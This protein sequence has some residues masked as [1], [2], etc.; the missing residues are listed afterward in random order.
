LPGLNDWVSPMKENAL[1]GFGDHGEVLVLEASLMNLVGGGDTCVEIS[2][3]HQRAESNVHCPSEPYCN[4]TCV[5][6]VNGSCGYAVNEVCTCI[7]SP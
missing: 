4:S 5:S 3:T 7:P 6:P 1:V 2:A